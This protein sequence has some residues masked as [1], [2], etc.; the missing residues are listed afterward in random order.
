MCTSYVF[1]DP[2]GRAADLLGCDTSCVV[3]K[4]A[5]LLLMR[6]GNLWNENHATFQTKE[7]RTK[8]KCEAFPSVDS[9]N[10]MNVAEL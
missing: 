1:P 6:V 2:D 5:E 3:E 10:S 8:K 9:I 7:R 4:K